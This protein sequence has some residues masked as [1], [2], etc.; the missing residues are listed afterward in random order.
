MGV[1]SHHRV[2]GEVF[3]HS[4]AVDVAARCL[5]VEDVAARCLAVE[6]VAAHC[7]GVGDVVAR[8]HPGH[9]LVYLEMVNV[10]SVSISAPAT[11]GL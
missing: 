1:P 8:R 2:E 9:Y 10:L 11:F 5:E 3:R 6:D 7:L 4:Q